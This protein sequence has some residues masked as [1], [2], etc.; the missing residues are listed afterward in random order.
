MGGFVRVL[1]KKTNIVILTVVSIVFAVFIVLYLSTTASSSSQSN[2]RLL[3]RSCGIHYSPD[4]D[5]RCYYYRTHESA[6][7][8]LPLVL[9]KPIKQ[10]SKAFD[11]RNLLVYI[12]GGP[13]QGYMTGPDEISHWMEWL[14]ERQSTFDV[15][16]FDPRGTGDGKP[17]AQ[18]SAY[19][20]K[21]RELIAATPEFSEEYRMLNSALMMCFDEYGQK[22]AKIFPDVDQKY[23]YDLFATR[24]Q[25]EDVNGMVKSLGYERAHLWGV[26]YGTRLALTAAPYDV[27]KSLILESVYPFSKGLYSDGIELYRNSFNTHERLYRLYRKH[28]GQPVSDYRNLYRRALNRLQGKP[29]TLALKS[30][31]DDDEVS[32]TLTGMRLLEFSF[33]TLYSPYL[34]DVYYAGIEAY[35]ES[36]EV[37]DALLLSLETFV[38]NI[39][40]DQFSVVVYFATECLD[41]QSEELDDLNFV[42]DGFPE[43]EAYFAEGFAYDFC[44]DYGL[45]SELS[46]SDLKYISKPTLI[47]SGELDPITPAD[48]GASLEVILPEAQHVTLHDTGHAGLKGVDCNWHFLNEF[49]NTGNV[50][51]KIKCTAEPL[52]P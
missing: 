43:I 28:H 6:G 25:A 24:H 33:S 3:S 52:W 50:K 17:A 35:A 40:D 12:P 39:V 42:F 13:G 44:K 14:K 30:W 16:L 11:E 36:G 9:L 4:F 22:L 2:T 45:S 51:V 5:L 26:S 46:V 49:I 32:F 10:E 23:L 31:K 18:C 15:L 38:N 1:L 29:L 27:V 48:W 8:L 41:G 37:N 47:F 34:Y 21:V 7:F 19:L 20:S